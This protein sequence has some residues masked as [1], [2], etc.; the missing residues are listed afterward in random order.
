M[1]EPE[2]IA[3]IDPGGM[4]DII[5]SLP[6]QLEAGMKVGGTVNV[7]LGEAQRIFIVG[8]GG[9]AIGGDVFAAWLADRAKAAI[10]V[11]RDYHLPSYARP[12]DLL[13][14]VSYS[15][16]TEE[17][18]AA[19]AE[20][21]KLGCR[22]VAI[23]SG[24]KLKELAR[25]AGLR[26]IP[27]P[28]GLPPRGAFGHMFGILAGLGREWAVGDLKAELGQAAVHLRDLRTQFAP[29]R[30]MRRN[31][32]KALALRIRP[33]V[34]VIYGAGPFISIA[35][36]WQTQLNENSK[37]LAFASAFPEADHNELVGWIEDPRNRSHRPILLRD[38]D[39]APG[40]RRQ[41]D[42]TVSLMSRK[43]KVEQVEDD[44][45][46]LVSRMLG[47]LYLGDYVSLYLAALRRV[48]PFVL[49]PIQA[50]KAKLAEGPR[51]G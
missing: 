43:A 24:G 7:P 50:L 23:T 13:V 39:E 38:R 3:R 20:G 32:A 5:A 22:G 51:K 8:M 21:T 33:T 44:G 6:E 19:T 2:A 9:S 49:R 46:T 37:V 16:N 34:P 27:L 48:D 30:A 28:T 47:T 42:I 40:L 29:E 11:V 25:P 17:T 18:L 12:E 15:G 31:R 10:Q 14:A 41:L 4:R 45:S 1:L 36:R 35:K 26:V